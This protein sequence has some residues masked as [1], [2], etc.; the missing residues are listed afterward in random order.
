L[1]LGK[2][3]NDLK[4]TLEQCDR[5][6]WRF[7]RFNFLSITGTMSSSERSPSAYVR[8]AA[9][10]HEH[11]AKMCPDTCDRL[12]FS[13]AKSPYI[14]VP[15]LRSSTQGFTYPVLQNG[16]LLEISIKSSGG[17]LRPLQSIH[18]SNASF[19]FYSKSTTTKS[20]SCAGGRFL[21]KSVNIVL[22]TRFC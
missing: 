6:V 10:Q 2:N 3:G 22:H 21:F 1:Y 5:Y 12:F 15:I 16:S 4:L 7:S 11:L 18:Q 8:S 13:V 14:L 20:N 17:F 9:P 19:F